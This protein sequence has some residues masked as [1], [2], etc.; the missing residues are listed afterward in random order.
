MRRFDGARRAQRHVPALNAILPGEAFQ[1]LYR[2]NAR[3]LEIFPVDGAAGEIKLGKTHAAHATA[4]HQLWFKIFTDHQ[5]RGA[6][7]DINHQLAAF[8]RLRVLNAHKNQACFFITGDDFNRVGDN[9]LGT[10]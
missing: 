7:A 9:L 2:C 4:F 8:F 10:F 6:T 3:A 1:F 5:F